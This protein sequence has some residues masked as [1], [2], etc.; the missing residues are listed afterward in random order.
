[1]TAFQAK[2][3][4]AE[5]YIAGL[6]ASGALLA[7]AGVIF[8]MVVGIVTFNAWP[9]ASGLFTFS[10]GQA[11]VNIGSLAGSGGSGSSARVLRPVT[12]RVAPTKRVAPTAVQPG[13]G[14]GTGI[15]GDS[16][17]QSPGG[18]GGD[19]GSQVQAGTPPSNG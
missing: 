12:V 5:T 16:V 18:S 3:R 2:A 14:D 9:Q 10:G 4:T 7:G 6:G 1:M 13:A 17:P 11:D 15:G 19:G 8:I